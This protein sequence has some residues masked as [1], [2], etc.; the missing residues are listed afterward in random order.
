MLI[1][2]VQQSKVVKIEFFSIET[3]SRRGGG[4][5]GGFIIVKQFNIKIKIKKIKFYFDRKRQICMVLNGN[6]NQIQLK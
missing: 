4:G 5:G 1:L 2:Y 3:E 6:T